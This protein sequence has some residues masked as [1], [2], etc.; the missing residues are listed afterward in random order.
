M[1]ETQALTRVKQT[2]KNYKAKKRQ[3]QKERII[4]IKSEKR[5]LG[6]LNHDVVFLENFISFQK[7]QKLKTEFT[8]SSFSNCTL[9]KSIIC[10]F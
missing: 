4:K 6:K 7:S 1:N 2:K 3:Q 8:V 10:S 9:T 5:L